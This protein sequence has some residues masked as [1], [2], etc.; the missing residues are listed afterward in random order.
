MTRALAY[1]ADPIIAAL[2]FI[3]LVAALAK[4]SS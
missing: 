3:G 4:A 2:V 1:L